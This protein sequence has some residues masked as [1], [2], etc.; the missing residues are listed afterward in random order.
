MDP[1][2]EWATWV[3]W[4]GDEPNGQ[5]IFAQVTEMLT[6][7]QI[8]DGFAFIYNG[9]PEEARDSPTFMQWIRYSYARSQA[10]G[11]RRMSDTRSDVV[12]LARL[13]DHVWR[14]PTVLSRERFVATRGVDRLY[15][16][17][18]FNDFASEGGAF[19]DPRIPAQDFQDLQARTRTV[20]EWV[21]TSVAHL[22]AKEKPRGGPP[23]QAVHDAVDDIADL[24][25]KYAGLIR[26]VHF[27]TGVIMQ[28]WPHVF[29]VP[30]I[31]DDDRYRQAMNAVHAAERRRRERPGVASGKTPG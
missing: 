9:L 26:G 19:I 23:L 1:E 24:F 30:W 15:S 31:P 3:S 22:T 18:V 10:I 28:P 12:S 2:R 6:F 21:N 5:T 13:I 17:H 8:W 16:E 29:R 27:E 4:L 7:R 20:R 25:V 11:V 14:Y